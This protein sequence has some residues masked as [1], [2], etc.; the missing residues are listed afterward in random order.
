MKIDET[1]RYHILEKY[2]TCSISKDATSVSLR[3]DPGCLKGFALMAAGGERFEFR[4]EPEKEQGRTACLLAVER[5]W[6]DSYIRAEFRIFYK[7]ML[8]D[9][10]ELDVERVSKIVIELPEPLVIKV[11]AGFMQPPNGITIRTPAII[12]KDGGI[13][14]RSPLDFFESLHQF[15][16]ESDAAAVLLSIPKKQA[17]LV[18]TINARRKTE[19][20][21][22][23]LHFHE[24]K[25]INLESPALFLEATGGAGSLGLTIKFDQLEEVVFSSSSNPSSNLTRLCLPLPKA[26]DGKKTSRLN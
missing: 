17:M 25:S 6:S 22:F 11:G 23:P 20:R 5:P 14:L 12:L 10:D 1:L 26:T 15:L 18:R 3:G 8:P 4:I 13:F 9:L 19:W 16:M 24:G 2:Y 21:T 7:G